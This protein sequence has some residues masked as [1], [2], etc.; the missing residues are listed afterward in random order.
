MLLI[1]L[2]P[3]LKHLGQKLFARG[4]GTVLEM[5]NVSN[6]PQEDMEHQKEHHGKILSVKVP[7]QQVTIVQPV[8]QVSF[9]KHVLLIQQ[10][11]P[12][13]HIIVPR[14]KEDN[15]LILQQNIQHLKL[16]NLLFVQEKLL[17]MPTNTVR[18][19]S[20]SDVLFGMVNGHLVHQRLVV[21]QLLP[22]PKAKM[23]IMMALLVIIQ[24]LLF[25][26]QQLFPVAV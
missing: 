7:V 16:I 4:D 9:Q 10:V 14:V 8:L 2:S 22:L 19:V 1:Q 5:V 24:T 15:R 11:Q 18:E 13:I 6:V 26:R 21:L 3:I 17:V 20:D 23:L 12:P 25:L